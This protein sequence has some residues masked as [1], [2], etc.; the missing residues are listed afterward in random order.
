MNLE[1]TLEGRAIALRLER[2]GA[3]WVVNG[4]EVSVLEAEPGIYSV[5]LDGRSFEARI[6]RTA[7]GAWAVTI[8]GRRY[9][10]EVRDPRRLRRRRGGLAG[11]GRQ[12]VSSPMPGRVV[13]VLIAEGEQVEAGQ[14]LVVVEAM[15]MQNEL[16]A[17]KAGRIVTLSAHVG[18]TV[19]ADEVLAVIE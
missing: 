15:K 19:A 3:N 4:R 2:Q 11:E 17:P 18:A 7:G 10:L 6:D 16:K 1:V 8:G 13:R 9:A 14:G 12:K 5:L